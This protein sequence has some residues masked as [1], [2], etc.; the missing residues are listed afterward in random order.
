ME[1]AGS[2]NERLSF[3]PG[4]SKIFVQDLP[5]G[6]V[7]GNLKSFF[8]TML[9]QMG[10]MLP[11]ATAVFINSFEELDKP[12]TDALKSKFHKFLNVG[13]FNF[14]SPPPATPDDSSCLPWLDK[15]EPASVAYIGFGSVAIP[16]KEELVA[17]AE[18]LEGSG[19]PF[20]WSLKDKARQNLPKGI[21]DKEKHGKVVPWA[22]QVD[23]LSHGAVGVFVTHS[24]YNSMLE[25]IAGGVPMICRPFFGDQMINGRMIEDVW[26]IG[27]KV[28]GGVFTKERMERYLKMVLSQEHGKRMR[29][30][31]QGLRELA[32]EA[33]GPTGSSTENFKLL[34]DVIAKP[35]GVS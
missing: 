26:E 5:E 15:Q 34:L 24:G 8:P 12:T 31:I 10:L 32:T 2:G 9:H 23:I 28:E 3:I 30:K 17:I 14:V 35:S 7:F 21:L 13:P 11:Q 20:I 33:V 4:M 18:A 19:V 22:P 29:A 25:S 27:I 1:A 6:I 16:P